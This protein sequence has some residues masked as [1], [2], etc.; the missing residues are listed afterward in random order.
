MREKRPDEVFTPKGKFV[1]PTMYQ[2]RQHLEQKLNKALFKPRHIIVFGESGCGK[3]WLYK[4]V[5][6]EKCINFEVINSASIQLNNSII[7][8]FQIKVSQLSPEQLT[9]RESTSS[10]TGSAGFIKGE[11]KSTKKYEVIKRDAY[12]DLIKLIHRKQK[13]NLSFIVIDNL[14][15]IIQSEK[16]VE[17]L[18]SLI[19]YLDDDEYAKYNVRLLLVGTLS[20]IRDYFSKI[21][22]SQTII[23]R[24]QELP[25]VSTL[26]KESVTKLVET[27]LKLLK[28]NVETSQGFSLSTVCNSVDWYSSGV[29]QYVHEI[30]LEVAIEAKSSSNTITQEVFDEALKCW[31]ESNLVGEMSRF[32]KH[33]NSKSTRKGRRNQVLFTIGYMRVKEFNSKDVEEQLRNFFPSSTKGKSI[34]V[35]QC[36]SELA[37]GD[38]PLIKRTAKNTSFRFVDPKIQIIIRW[39]MRKDSTENIN[40]KSFDESICMS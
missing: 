20:N 1:N 9:V 39:A 25:E 8:A 16:L 36:L 31:V 13:N 33:I 40:V 35:S 32:E 29:P 21:L 12:L 11:V 26:P 15:H 34:N 3:T 28:I 4:K 17:E 5:L 19:L 14:E 24:V 22:E 6:N 18:T 37:S 38:N 7:E 30:G 2:S 23:N 27:G 10:S